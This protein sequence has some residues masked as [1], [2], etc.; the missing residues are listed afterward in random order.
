M[1]VGDVAA[2]EG[3]LIEL[4]E[5]AGF[6]QLLLEASQLGGGAIAPD[7]AIGRRQLTDLFNPI[8]NRR[9]KVLQGGERLGRRGH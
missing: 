5:F 2:W 4:L 9:R 1:G 3:G 6:F 8:G 7:H